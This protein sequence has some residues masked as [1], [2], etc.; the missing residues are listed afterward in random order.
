MQRHRGGGKNLHLIFINLHSPMDLHPL[1]FFLI[2]LI[3]SFLILHLLYHL[4]LAQL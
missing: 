3:P 4:L 2:R 1:L